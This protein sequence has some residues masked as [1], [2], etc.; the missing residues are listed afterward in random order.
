MTKSH[1]NLEMPISESRTTS[2]PNEQDHIAIHNIRNSLRKRP[3]TPVSISEAAKIAG[4]RLSGERRYVKARTASTD[5]KKLELSQRGVSRSRLQVCQ[6]STPITPSLESRDGGNRSE[7]R[8]HQRP[9]VQEHHVSVQ[10]TVAP[11]PHSKGELQTLSPRPEDNGDSFLEVDDIPADFEEATKLETPVST[12]T[13]I[14]PIVTG[15]STKNTARSHTSRDAN[16]G[17]SFRPR[18]ALLD[19][20]AAQDISLP[21]PSL[22]PVTAAANL[23]RREYFEDLNANGRD[24]RH[25]TLDTSSGSLDEGDTKSKESSN[26]ST[27][28][29]DLPLSSDG[30]PVQANSTSQQSANLSMMDIPTILASI[31]AMPTEMK[32]YLMYQILRRCSKPVLRL[33]AD[34]VVPTLRCDFLSLLPPELCQNI[35]GNLDFKSL[36]SAAQV[37]RKWR[38]IIDSDEKTWKRLFDKDGFTLPSGEL[39]RAI[40]EGWGWQYPSETNDFEQDIGNMGTVSG[41]SPCPII[42]TVNAEI[43]ALADALQPTAQCRRSKRKA[44]S[45]SKPASRKQQKRKESPV[46]IAAQFDY[47][48]LLKN[49][50]TPDGP[51]AAANAA[52]IAVPSTNT[53]LPSLRNIHLHKTLYQRHYKIRKSWMQD[54]IKPKHIAF[55]AHQRHV[56]TCLQFDNDKILTGSDDNHINVYDTRTGALRARLEG[57][58]GGVWALQY[59]GNVL[60]SGS[61]DRSVRVWDIERGVCTQVFQGH[62][63]TVRC[64][65]ILMPTQVG[66]TSD[67]RSI[68]MP[69]QPLIITGSRDSSLRVWKLPKSGD[70]SFIQIGQPQDESECPYFVRTLS[71][72]IHSVRAIA[73]YADTLVSGSYDCTVRVWKISTGETIHRLQGHS[74]KVYSVVLDHERNRCISGSMDNLVKVWSLDTGSVLYNLEGHASLVGLLDLQANR[75]VSAAADSTLRIWDPETG[76]CRNILS[77]HASAITCFQHDGQKVVSG[78]D[79]TL[80]MW[81]VN[82]GEFVK[83]LL[84]DLGGVWQVKFDERRCVAAVQR[85]DYTYIEVSFIYGID[86][87][88]L[89]M[90]NRCLTLVHLE[91]AFPSGGVAGVSLLIPKA[92][93]PLT[94]LVKVLSI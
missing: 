3:T 19:T 93:R 5:F 71:G 54:E 29:T 40:W 70:P 10:S 86:R 81:N 44:V 33:V 2:T 59:E 21:S 24:I 80:K 26:L 73:S 18:P 1:T 74:S 79:R 48:A 85:N 92:S 8:K 62:T 63:S 58:D 28:A 90:C 57:H 35:I 91:M 22:S 34:V 16:T 39:Q 61:T 82:T 27:W 50:S 7:C 65:Q 53:G 87:L 75:L 20:T 52:S 49:I 30:V 31:D 13:Q 78:S 32:S 60:V 37:S 23:H 38:Q 42:G 9:V 12:Q 45:R 68:M 51:Y 56:V 64:L 88:L 72:H 89:I 46:N 15:D 66:T 6:T 17:P 77:A 47:D 11:S 84:T 67:G 43:D 14:P 41:S 4:S 76:Y 94:C 25:L 83:D 36:C 69:R 55:K